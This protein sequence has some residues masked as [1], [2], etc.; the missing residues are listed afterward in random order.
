MPTATIQVAVVTSP[1]Q[2]A[3]VAG[4]NKV[5]AVN[6]PND[7]ATSYI[8]ANSAIAEQYSLAVPTI[9]TDSAINS[10][11]TYARL[12][13]TDGLRTFAVD[14]IL[15][16]STT[17]GST[18]TPGTSWTDFTDALA[19]PGGGSWGLADFATLEVKLRQVSSGS[20]K[21]QDCT[22]LWLVVDYT[23]PPPKAGN[24]LLVF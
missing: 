9:P 24:M 21:L 14:L 16:A 5:V 23:P 2:W 1:D 7:D 11:S 13:S 20:G 8:Q 19:R 3:L 12:R 22:S 6:Q 15:G 10:V 4:A 17:T 18:R